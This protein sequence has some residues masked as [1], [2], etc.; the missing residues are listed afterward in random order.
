MGLSGMDRFAEAVLL[1]RCAQEI[2]PGED[3]VQYIEKVERLVKS[4]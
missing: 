3:V 4:R 2:K 1:L